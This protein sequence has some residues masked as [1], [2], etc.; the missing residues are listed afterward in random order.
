MD[1]CMGSCMDSCMD[2]C[3]NTDTNQVQ[4]E[5]RRDDNVRTQNKVEKLL[6]WV[7]EQMGLFILPFSMGVVR[8]RCITQN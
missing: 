5:W 1:S 8:R 4:V 3:V 2:S 6:A 7:Q